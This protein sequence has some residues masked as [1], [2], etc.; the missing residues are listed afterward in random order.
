MGINIA[1]QP[2][3]NGETKRVKDQKEEKRM[4]A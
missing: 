2:W 1:Y 3:Q 4:R